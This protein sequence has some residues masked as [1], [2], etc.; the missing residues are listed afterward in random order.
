MTSPPPA[1]LRSPSTESELKELIS[2][3]RATLESTADGILV[4]D[5]EGRISIYNRPF[6]AMWRLPED[7]LISRDDDR[8][9]AFVLDQLTSP[10]QFLKKVRELYA[11]PE[12]ESFDV[13]EF[14]DGRILERYSR[15][16]WVEGQAVGRV[17][18]FRDVTE[19]RRVEDALRRERSFLRQVID[20]NPHLI[21]AKDRAGRF[22]LV[23]E[24]VGAVYG[25]TPE[26]L[27]G[28]TDA[29]FN[30]NAAEVEFFRRADL[31][32]MDSMREKIIPEER[33]TNS[34][35]EVRWLQTVKRPVVAEN[36]R[37]DQ[38]LGVATDIT[39]RRRAEEVLRQSEERFAKAFRASPAAISISRLA[40]GRYLDVNDA[41]VRLLGY[42]RDD[43]LRCTSLELGLWA[44]PADRP[45]LAVNLER[46]GSIR[47]F[48]TR[49]KTKNG[50]IRDVVI[51]AERIEVDHE[52]CI[53]AL[54]SDVTEPKRL[55]EQL[56]QSQKME[57][58]G[59]MAG[60]IA[61]DFN[62]LLTTIL[63]YSELILRGHPADGALHEEVAEI[64]KAS[65]RAASLTHQL[66]AFSRKQV[67]APRVLSLNDTVSDAVKLLGRLIGEDIS[68]VTDLDPALGAVRADPIQIE[69]VLLNLAIN[70]RDAMPRGGQITLRTR[71]AV[72]VEPL[73]GLHFTL[74]PGAY[75]TLSVM[76]NGVGMDAETQRRIFEPFFTTKEMGKGTGLGLSTVYGIVKQSGGY[77]FV[78]SE[79][80]RGTRFEIYLPHVDER[81]EATRPAGPVLPFSGG[82]ETI[83]IAEDE[84]S[85]RRLARRVL[86]AHGYAVLEAGSAE[87]A[88]ALAERSPG[89]VRLL[90]TDIVMTGASGRDLAR[91]ML[92]RWPATKVLFVSGYADGSISG[93]GGLEPGT[94]F[95]QK[96]FTPDLL[97]QKVREVLDGKSA[98]AKAKS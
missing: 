31:E 52:P 84:E 26:G 68:L 28:K 4:V 12:A 21:F 24:A 64:K 93:E 2:L 47:E 97:V 56:R 71:N 38:I 57:A 81:A 14:K 16:H 25:T 41:F 53:L 27:I 69:Q 39:D 46:D 79:P 18:S 94:N 50:E 10:D 7:V 32:V 61:H 1:S 83:L 22:T 42:D 29:D 78:T 86:E 30:S 72:L 76:D 6:A 9:I 35:G 8:A 11:T 65:E 15:P 3:L 45:R 13:L 19:T 92:S 20:I 80:G 87:E 44:D 34:K 89:A 74:P 90:V 54:S 36:G 82:S 37:V 48:A 63:G 40:D 62:N 43:V 58:I 60:G 98:E 51:A 49:F 75:A 67:I 17:W 55:E 73:A 96:P 77:I 95:L 33:I 91:R 5:R 66:L 70:S 88:F 59:R 23:N 85:L